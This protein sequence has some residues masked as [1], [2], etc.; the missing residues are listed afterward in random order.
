MF[1]AEKGLRKKK[2]IVSSHK[3]YLK[4]IFAFENFYKSISWSN[5]FKQKLCVE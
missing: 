2:V 1:L 4:K 3:H 5:Q